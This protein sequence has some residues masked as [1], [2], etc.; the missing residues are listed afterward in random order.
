MPRRWYDARRHG[1]VGLATTYGAAL[2]TS[3]G[4]HR[5]VLAAR[6]SFVWAAQRLECAYGRRSPSDAFERVRRVEVLGLATMPVTIF[7]AA[8]APLFGQHRAVLA[9][10]HTF[11]WAAQRLE[12]AIRGPCHSHFAVQAIEYADKAV[13]VGKT[14]PRAVNPN[15]LS[16]APTFAAR[17]QAGLGVLGVETVDTRG[18]GGPT[19]QKCAYGRHS[20]SNAFKRVRRVEVLGLAT[21]GSD[22]CE[23]RQFRLCVNCLLACPCHCPRGCCL[24]ARCHHFVC[25]LQAGLGV[26]G[27]ETG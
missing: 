10:R 13:G 22:P 12:C 24:C 26:L 6:H 4:Q 14:E 5:A 21:D 2:A 23:R 19:S 1:C 7:G 8:L 17:E 11:V 27:V 18:A 20:P 15:L 9:A 3:L 25:H 16:V